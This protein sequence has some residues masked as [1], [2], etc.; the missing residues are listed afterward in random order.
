MNDNQLVSML[1]DLE[2]I[3][4]GQQHQLP[5]RSGQKMG[6]PPMIPTQNYNS[7]PAQQVPPWQMPPMQVQPVMM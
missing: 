3:V 1:N 2:G 5:G 7:M 4:V 6:R